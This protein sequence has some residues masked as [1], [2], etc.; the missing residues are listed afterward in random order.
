MNY[1]KSLMTCFWSSKT[2]HEIIA[3]SIWTWKVI[4][5]QFS[6]WKWFGKMLPPSISG[7]NKIIILQN[8]STEMWMITL[9]IFI[10]CFF[11]YKHSKTSSACMLY[12]A[13]TSQSQTHFWPA[14]ETASSGWVNHLSYAFSLGFSIK[15]YRTLY[16]GVEFIP[17]MLNCSKHIHHTSW[18]ETVQISPVS[19]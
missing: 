3:N 13:R 9:K 1:A 16:L 11:P 19:E 6:T 2:C 15:S 8:T 7:S 10:L 18:A 14:M 5:K 12:T 4:I 17:L